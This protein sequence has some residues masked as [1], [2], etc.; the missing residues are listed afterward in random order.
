MGIGSVYWPLFSFEGLGLGSFKRGE[1]GPIAQ[2]RSERTPDKRE[3]GGSN[4]PRP[5]REAGKAAW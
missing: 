3:V 1:D 4:P 2:F 5:T